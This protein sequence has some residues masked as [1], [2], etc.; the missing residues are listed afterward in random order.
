MT[1]MHSEHA[2]HPAL[3]PRERVQ[4]PP[5]RDQEQYS[6]SHGAA[7]PSGSL[8]HW[9]RAGVRGVASVSIPNV[10]RSRASLSSLIGLIVLIG[11]ELCFSQDAGKTLHALFDREWDYTMRESPTWASHLG[12]LRWNPQWDD[13]SPA[14]QD[15][16]ADHDH[17]V[18]K[19][20]SAID[21]TALSDED[22]TSYDLFELGLKQSIE[23]H[24][25]GFHLIPLTQ[26]AGIQTADELGDALQFKTVKD[27]DEWLA[28]LRAF[29]PHMSQTIS[30]MREGISKGMVQPRVVMDRVPAQ[31]AKQITPDPTKSPFYKPFAKMIIAIREPDRSRLKREAAEA[32][33]QFVT[34]SYREFAVFFEKE[35][36]PACL[37]GVGAWRLPEGE[38]RY[39]FL[40]RKYT[41]TDLTPQQIHDIGLAEVK[42]IGVEMERVKERVGFKGSMADFFQ[43]LRTNPKFFFRTPA[44][45]LKAYKDTAAGIAAK[46]PK[47]FKTLPRTQF[48]VERIPDKIAPDTT[49][50]YYRQPSAD[51][52]RPGAFS[53]NLFKPE[54]RPKWEMMALTLHESVPGHHL[55]IALAQEQKGLPT[56]RR[57]LECTA[58]VEGWALYSEWLGEEMGVYDDPYDK[59]GELTLEMWRAVRLVVDT[60]IHQ[61]KWTREEAIKFFRDHAPKTEQD[62]VNEVDRYIAWPGQ[63][64]AYKIGQLK[65]RELRSRAEIALGGKF[66]EREFHDAVLLGG[67]LP[68]KALEARIDDWINQQAK[69]TNKP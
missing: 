4:N 39:A 41:T 60:G 68:L 62:I 27:Y 50:A 48:V 46:L 49:T 37:D 33:A 63:A 20:I 19:E 17:D 32:V 43:D 29:P 28:R 40:C 11:T 31:I 35:Y 52:S 53:V 69:P 7:A 44:D 8:S 45:L 36:L 12:D 10:R 55:Q 6:I 51:G 65:I 56:F 24:D 16:R 64:L 34:P 58:F 30:L 14:A 61:L 13:V 25:L 54:T 3:S 59:M 26:R 15:R 57:H 66:D 67:A 2:A 38:K 9:E 21:R 22:R 1:S 23:S 18:L 5:S 47:H 42:R